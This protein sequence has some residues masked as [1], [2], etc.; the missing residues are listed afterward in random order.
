MPSNKIRR[1]FQNGKKIN[2]L[3]VLWDVMRQFVGYLLLISNTK[4]KGRY[5]LISD[6]IAQQHLFAAS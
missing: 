1:N 6:S 2:H 5:L 3:K 4:A